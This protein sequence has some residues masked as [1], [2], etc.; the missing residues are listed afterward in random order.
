MSGQSIFRWGIGGLAVGIFS[1]LM[2][3]RSPQ[4]TQVQVGNFSGN[5]PRSNDVAIATSDRIWQK[6]KRVQV[7]LYQTKEKTTRV[8]SYGA[9]KE[10]YITFTNDV[11]VPA[12]Q[13]MDSR[14]RE[15]YQGQS[16]IGERALK[17]LG[18]R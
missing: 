1:T 16:Q 14:V 10:E 11:W 6:D 8:M 18:T 2:F 12:E 5:N 9:K 4:I 15:A 13:V 17:A 7:W 3:V